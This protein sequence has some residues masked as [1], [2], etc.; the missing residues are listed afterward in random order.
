MDCSKI[1]DHLYLGS[2]EFLKSGC[3]KKY[4]VQ[5]DVIINVAKECVKCTDLVLYHHYLYD[6]SPSEDLY[7]HFDEIA[8]LIHS[9][10]MLHKNVY[11]HCYAGKSRSAS[12]VLVYLMKYIN[13]SLTE[14][15]D[16]VNNLRSI[17]PNLGFVNQLMKYE[18]EHNLLV[19]STLNYD[20]C[21]V[22]NIFCVTG[23]ATK[24]TV[25]TVYNEC[26]KDIELTMKKLF[27]YYVRC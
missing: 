20:N 25:K 10:I 9:Y 21:V 8:D 12:F 6:D 16:Y 3:Y 19:D 2:Y 22:D 27:E 17:Y 14:A 13:Y 7:V 26:N 15:F 11:I 23:F 24:E 4:D 5:F 18:I 1:I